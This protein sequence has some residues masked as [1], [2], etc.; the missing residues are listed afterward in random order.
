VDII[1][2]VSIQRS[3]LF[4]LYKDFLKHGYFIKHRLIQKAEIAVSNLHGEELIPSIRCSQ[5][6]QREVGE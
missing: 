5:N 3:F 1:G 6:Y 2:K 4:N